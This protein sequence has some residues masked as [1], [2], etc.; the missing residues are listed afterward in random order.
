MGEDL[1]KFK[2]YKKQEWT[3]FDL[4]I[5]KKTSNLKTESG[6][7]ISLTSGKGKITRSQNCW[8]W[9]QEDVFDPNTVEHR[10]RKWC[11][12]HII[13]LRNLSGCGGAPFNLILAIRKQRQVGLCELDAS[14]IYIVS[15][16]TAKATEWDP[17][18]KNNTHN[19]TKQTTITKSKCRCVGD[20]WNLS[21]REVETVGKEVQGHLQ[22]NI[23]FKMKQVYITLN[24]F[25]GRSI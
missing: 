16:S 22:I 11:R 17:V 13:K 24:V 5:L 25:S 1:I 14:L 19:Q 18:K 3:Y 20:T 6:W 12:F 15:P 2:F 9:R 7:S 23:Q 8:L 10:T 4:I 21:T